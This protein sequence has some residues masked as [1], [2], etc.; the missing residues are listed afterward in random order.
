MLVL[1]FGFFTFTLPYMHFDRE[2]AAI[3]YMTR[4]Y[5]AMKYEERKQAASFG[6]KIFLTVYI[7]LV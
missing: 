2:L 5:I 4:D 1:I 7:Y 3:P 6:K